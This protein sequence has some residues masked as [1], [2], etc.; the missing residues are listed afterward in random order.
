MLSLV[1]G[2][3]EVE[4]VLLLSRVRVFYAAVN[5]CW[6]AVNSLLPSFLPTHSLTIYCKRAKPSFYGAQD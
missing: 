2:F 1:R 5:V 6:F 3:E 4:E